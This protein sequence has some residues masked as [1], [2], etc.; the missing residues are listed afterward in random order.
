MKVV[1]L[2]CDKNEDLWYPFYHCMEKYWKNH[3]EVI[4]LTESKKNNYYKTIMK[5][6]P[7]ELWS[8]RIRESLEE[9]EDDLVLVM[10]D[11]VFIRHDVDVD[12]IEYLCRN[13]KGACINFEKSFD[14]NDKDTEIDEIKKR[15][16]RSP[17]EVSLMCG[18]WNRRALQD[19]LREDSD[20]W[21]IESR[22]N[23]YGYDF[24]INGG[25]YII[26]WGYETWQ[27]CGV[28]KG[29]WCREAK[30]FF[31]NEGIKIDYDKRGFV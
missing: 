19:I 18:L 25:E 4:Y 2:S 12:R 27:Y 17:Y 28:M 13:F 8:K 21:T 20:P 23:G 22:G 7:L 5:K 10:V 1:V 9:I 6:Y 14:E 15:G 3:P 24:Y 16:K 30:F 29:K 31:D 26:D 11:D